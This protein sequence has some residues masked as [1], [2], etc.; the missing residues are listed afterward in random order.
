MVIDFTGYNVVIRED[1]TSQALWMGKVEAYNKEKNIIEV[2][3]FQTIDLEKYRKL[4]VFLFLNGQAYIYH[5]TYRK[6]GGVD[7]VGIALYQGKV[8][9]DRKSE[10]FLINIE[11]EIVERK[12]ETEE[13]ASNEHHKIQIMDISRSGIRIQGMEL[14]LS[15]NDWIAVSFAVLGLEKTC[16]AKIIRIGNSKEDVTEYGCK[17]MTVQK[18]LLG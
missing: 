1:E 17:L 9:N 18:Y 14:Q 15:I 6:L 7:R 13:I 11:A 4:Q 12:S 16:Y 8:K 3:G 2:D 5:G 10:R